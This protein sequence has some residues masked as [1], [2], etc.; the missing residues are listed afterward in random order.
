MPAGPFNALF[1]PN[2]TA[3]I[4]PILINPPSFSVF[5]YR[6]CN[7]LVVKEVG[8]KDKHDFKVQ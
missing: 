3:K 5:D 1:S 6:N 4:P 2:C 8:K 7:K